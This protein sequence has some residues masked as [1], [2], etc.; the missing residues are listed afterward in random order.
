M[1][2]RNLFLRSP[3]FPVVLVGRTQAYEARWPRTIL[4]ARMPGGMTPTT[5]DTESGAPAS[6]NRQA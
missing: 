4:D 6:V 2:M 3:V 5:D 1:R